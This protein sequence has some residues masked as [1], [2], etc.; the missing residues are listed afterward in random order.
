MIK[1]GLMMLYAMPWEDRRRYSRPTPVKKLFHPA[2]QTLY[3]PLKRLGAA[4]SMGSEADRCPE[5]H[6]PESDLSNCNSTSGI[7]A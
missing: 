4:R 3:D 6:A 1:L 7:Y 2:D 5:N